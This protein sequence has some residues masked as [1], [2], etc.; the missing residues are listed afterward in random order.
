M[1]SSIQGTYFALGNSLFGGVKLTKNADPDK[2]KYYRYRIGFDA[3]GSFSL[4]NGSGFGKNA[5]TFANDALIGNKKI[6]I[7]ILGST[8]GLDDT[9]L[10][11]EKE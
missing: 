5:V 9:T 10:T 1:R 4:S 3:C 7:L 11:A 2:Y 6:H 8:D